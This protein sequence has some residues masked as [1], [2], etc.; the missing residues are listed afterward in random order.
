MK[1]V[2]TKF[3]INFAIIQATILATSI[4]VGL[5]LPSTSG[6]FATCAFLYLI[7]G[8]LSLIPTALVAATVAILT[9]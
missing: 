5:Q 2:F 7:A 4:S 8:G 3:L 9:K 6:P 1:S